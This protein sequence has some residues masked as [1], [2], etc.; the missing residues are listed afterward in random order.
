MYET[1]DG[2]FTGICDAIREKDGTTALISHQDIP[3]RIGAISEDGGYVIPPFYTYNG[4]GM[5]VDNGVVSNFGLYNCVYLG[6]AFR[7]LDNLWE[8]RTKFKTPVSWVH[9]LN[10]IF[11]S[12]IHRGSPQCDIEVK[13]GVRKMW[14]GISTDNGSSWTNI[15]WSD[16]EFEL[17]KWYWMRYI[18]DGE[19]YR[20]LISVN[21]TDFEEIGVINFS[22]QFYQPEQIN[23]FIFG[24]SRSESNIFDGSIDLKE[25]YIKIGNEIW[26][27]KG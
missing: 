18:F 21:G 17:D 27:G 26:W 4:G 3:A 8:I 22:G 7:P 1:V 11:S 20:I 19:K 24:G 5:K 2:L 10:T 13:N 9:S 16:Y 15:V 12:Q 6:K 14:S 23:S 25:T